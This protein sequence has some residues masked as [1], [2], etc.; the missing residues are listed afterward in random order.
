MGV[1]YGRL[2]GPTEAPRLTT[3]RAIGQRDYG[4]GVAITACAWYVLSTMSKQK[5][6]KGRPSSGLD[7]VL[8]I[9]VREDLVEALDQRLNQEKARHPGRT[10]TRADIARELLYRAMKSEERK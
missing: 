7:K 10:I 8:Y 2:L 6:Q 5:R 4:V 9:R 1:R 3:S